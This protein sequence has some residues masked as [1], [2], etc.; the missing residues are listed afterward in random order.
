MVKIFIAMTW[1]ACAQGQSFGEKAA[2]PLAYDDI[3][4]RQNFA[5]SPREQSRQ[6]MLAADPAVSTAWHSREFY[7]PI[8]KN[9]GGLRNYK[10]SKI[11][12]SKYLL[13]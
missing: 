6:L 12:L 7:F 2:I 1:L 8:G 5:T 9:L 4:R 11:I 3:A 10:S 13:H